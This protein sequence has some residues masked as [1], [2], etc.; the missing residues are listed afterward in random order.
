MPWKV[1]HEDSEKAPELSKKRSTVDLCRAGARL[2]WDENEWR[3]G[4][5][6]GSSWTK[7]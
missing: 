4:E 1:E 6:E 3:G 2:R 5:E 7:L